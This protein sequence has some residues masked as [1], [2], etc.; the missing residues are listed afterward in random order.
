[1]H[2]RDL[3]KGL[4]YPITVG[5]IL[6]FGQ[7]IFERYKTTRKV[8][9]VI[10]G[11][12][13]FSQIHELFADAKISLSVVWWGK[14][15]TSSEPLKPADPRVPSA[16]RLGIGVQ[17]D[18]DQLQIYKVTIRN[19]GNSPIKDLPIRLVFEEPSEKFSVFTIL[20]KTNPAHEFGAIKSDHN[21]SSPRF[22]Y[23]LLN[24]GNEDVITVLASEKRQLR[25]YAGGEGV[26]LDV[27]TASETAPAN[28]YIFII[29]A[30][31]GGAILG[32]VIL[33]VMMR[34]RDRQRPLEGVRD[35]HH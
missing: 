11:P 17:M 22:I 32:M 24:P 9:A 25:V 10:E 33:Y 31:V 19:S 16:P 12:F 28:I 14:Q 2:G 13:S 27:R 21:M 8:S 34:F 1:M 26:S 3:L 30:F 23:E 18:L 5:I 35:D 20:H 15:S 7:F 29:I 6:L 4:V